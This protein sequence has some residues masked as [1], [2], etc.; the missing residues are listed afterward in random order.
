[1]ILTSTR[2]QLRILL[3]LI[4]LAASSIAHAEDTLLKYKMMGLNAYQIRLLMMTKG[5]RLQKPIPSH[6][7]LQR[8]ALNSGGFSYSPPPAD[9][10][11]QKSL[12]AALQPYRALVMKSAKK[13]D[14]KP[15][16]ISAVILA[17]SNFRPYSVS[18]KGAQ[19]LMQLMPGTAALLKVKNP[20]DPAQNIDGGTKYLKWMLDE[21]KRV[22]L[23]L[24]AYNAGPERVRTV[25]RVPWIAETRLYVA[26]VIRFEQ[27]FR[28]VFPE[29][30]PVEVA[31]GK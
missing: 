10:S 29:N 5:T 3:P 16:L 26:R 23:A 19:G 9:P 28:D 4:L 12:T 8:R 17:E 24:A 2:K 15:T 7:L 21:F 31:G 27:R 22:D 30:V 20:F 14:V 25:K 6:R 1:M 13:Y 18:H 11:S